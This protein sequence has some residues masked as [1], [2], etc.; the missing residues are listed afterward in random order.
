MAAAQVPVWLDCDVGH[1]DAMALIL[2]AYHPRIRLLGVSSVSGN[3]PLENTTENA[4]RVLQAAGIAGVKVHRGAARPLVKEARHHTKVH[5]ASGLDGSDLLPPADYEQ[6]LDASTNAVNAMR[7]AIMDSSEPVAIVAVAPLT[8]VALLLSVY[9]EVVPRIRMLS[10]MGG[11]TGTGSHRPARE[12]NLSSDPEALHI[13]LRSGI[14]HIA[15]VPLDVT[16]SVLASRAVIDRISRTTRNP[17]FAQLITDLLGF[18]ASTHADE[19]G[20]GAGAPLHDPVAMLY[21]VMRDA[22]EEK[23]VWVDAGEDVGACNGWLRCD[24]DGEHALPPNCWVTT[25]VDTARFWDAMVGA[26]V[27]ASGRCHLIG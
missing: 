25:A 10:I 18:S 7:R 11:V 20:E 14:A 19:L 15:L 27:E 1:D 23:H 17:R 24:M 3:A 6:Y 5:G 13:V 16:L 2:G 21:V 9:P 26:L 12:F 4:V 22:F 8:N